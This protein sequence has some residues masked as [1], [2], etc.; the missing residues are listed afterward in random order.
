MRMLICAGL[1]QFLS[2]QKGQGLQ[3]CY[4]GTSEEDQVNN[5]VMPNRSLPRMVFCSV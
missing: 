4:I 2:K 1:V 3:A 5:A